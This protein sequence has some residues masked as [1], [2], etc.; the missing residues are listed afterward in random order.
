MNDKK[1]INPARLLLL[2]LGVI[3]AMN[4]ISSWKTAN[5][6]TYYELRQLFE[7]ET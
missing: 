1:Q 6:V 5:D 3:L 2:V 7:Q 4:L